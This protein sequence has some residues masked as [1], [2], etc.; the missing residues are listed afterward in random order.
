MR[1]AIISPYSIG[2]IRGNITTVKRISRFLTRAGV[3]LLV[4]PADVL[5]P[6]E[7]EHRLTFFAPQLI[8]AFHASY[9][10]GIARL[11]AERFNLPFIITITG[12][13]LHDPLLRNH[14]DTVRAIT[15]AQATACFDGNEAA[16]LAGYF[17]QVADR[18]V[19]VPQGVEALH[20]AAADSFG[21]ADDAFVLLL[22]AAI[23][24]VKQIEFPLQ[25]LARLATKIPAIRLVIAGGIIDQDYA[26]TIRS[27]LCDAWYATWLGEIPLKRMGVLYARADVVLNCSRF[28]S[29]P[30]TL[31]EAM[32]MGRPVLAADIQGNRTLVRHGDTGLLYRDTDSFTESVVRLAGD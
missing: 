14:Q 1:I 23:R 22:P 28:E 15:A 29:M 30:N 10:G 25:A 26:A 3:E 27:L 24:P 4:L 8:H 32:A 21:L 6:A 16:E 11:L 7:M 20:V 5:S 12:S 19:V 31:L 2:P 9:C 17:P 18:V 13:D